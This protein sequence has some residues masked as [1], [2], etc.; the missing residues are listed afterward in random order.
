MILGSRFTTRVDGVLGS[1]SMPILLEFTGRGEWWVTPVYDPNC[2]KLRSYFWD[3][4][5]D[6]FRLCTTLH[7]AFV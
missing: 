5:Y 2:P 4:L 7:S 1:F 6:L 3:E